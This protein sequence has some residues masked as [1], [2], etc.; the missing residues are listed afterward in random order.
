MTIVEN[1]RLAIEAL[2]VDGTLDGPL[3][4]PAPFDMLLSD[5][6]MPELDG[7]QAARILRSR[8][9]ALPIIALTAHAMSDDMAKCL[10][11]GCD[12]YATKPID[13]NQ[14]LDLCRQ[15]R[16]GAFAVRRNAA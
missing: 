3:A 12:A 7:Y 6:Q 8:N 1:G 4:N 9:C 11:A 5:M 16:S 10:H 14:L 2:T 15:A 13:R